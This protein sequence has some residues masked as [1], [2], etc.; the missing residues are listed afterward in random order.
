MLRAG[1]QPDRGEDTV[2]DAATEI[3]Y[4]AEP[5]LVRGWRDDNQVLVAPATITYRRTP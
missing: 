2:S 3:A 5:H 1:R 4:D